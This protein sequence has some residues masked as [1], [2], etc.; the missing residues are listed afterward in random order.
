MRRFVIIAGVDYERNGVNFRIFADNR[1][2][3]L[4]ATNTAKEDLTFQVFD[5]RTGSV[6][7]RAVTYPGG[8]KTEKVAAVTPF[9]PVAPTHYN[10]LGSGTDVH[11]ELR[12]GIRGL[13]SVTDVYAAVQ[14]IGRDDP[15]T[16]REL[17]FFSHAWHGGPILINSFDDGIVTGP[18]LSVGGPPTRTSVGA[19]RDPDDFDPR[20]AKDFTPPTMTT[21]ELAEFRAA[22]HTAG[23]GWSWGCA[24]PRTIHEILHKLEQHR[25]YRRS[26]L[27]D[28]T[29]L[30]FTNFRADHIGELTTTLGLAVPDP[31]RVEL[32]FGDLR[33]YFCLRTMDSY[34]HHLAVAADRIV[35]AGP[36]GTYSEYDT[37]PRP[38][39]HVHDGFARHFTFYANYLGFTYDPEGRHYGAFLPT[40]TC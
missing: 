35:F 37:G 3:R 39:M 1:V 21:A 28:S 19:A 13:M 34:S 4:V 29:K 7:T 8:K 33:R 17:S 26:G 40:F 23:I 22:F 10:R 12:D 15:G 36:I 9:T 11:Y 16:L 32:T 20:P 14:T 31:K 30:V 24:F 5:V 27:A 38:L 18:P 2:K 25:D 6:V